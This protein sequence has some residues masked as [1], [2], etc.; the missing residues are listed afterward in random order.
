MPISQSELR[1]LP[2]AYR[3]ENWKGIPTPEWQQRNAE[4]MPQ[5]SVDIPVLRKVSVYRYPGWNAGFGRWLWSRS[6]V[7]ACRRR[8]LR[9]FGPTRRTAASEGSSEV[10]E[11]IWW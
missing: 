11:K 5:E 4:D 2:L 1:A 7:V 6:L 10:W 9:A 3:Q 8:G